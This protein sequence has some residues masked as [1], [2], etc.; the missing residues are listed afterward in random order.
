MSKAEVHQAGKQAPPL[1]KLV[2]TARHVAQEQLKLTPSE[3]LNHVV[4]KL[5]ISEQLLAGLE[6]KQR[7]VDEVAQQLEVV[8][9]AA[10]ES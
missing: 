10:V 5:Q 9:V 7:M 4:V 3:E 2:T 6:A 1:L 8:E